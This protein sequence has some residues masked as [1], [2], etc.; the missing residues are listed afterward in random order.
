MFMIRSPMSWA[1][2]AIAVIG[3]APVVKDLKPTLSA[4][5]SG[6]IWFASAGTLVRSAEGSRFVPG[7]PVVLSGEL[8][9]PSS[10]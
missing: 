3:C 10:P 5:D 9:V 1:C 4:T 6:A 7:A 8:R 2:V